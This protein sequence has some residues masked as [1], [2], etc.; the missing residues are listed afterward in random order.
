M[1]VKLYEK[2]LPHA[3]VPVQA[4]EMRQMN[5]LNAVCWD[6]IAPPDFI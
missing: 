6:M 4:A 5:G 3:M 2:A 1:W